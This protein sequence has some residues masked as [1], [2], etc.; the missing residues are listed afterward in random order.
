[1]KKILW[2]ICVLCFLILSCAS[3]RNDGTSSTLTLE[4]QE[5]T[6]T[7]SGTIQGIITVKRDNSGRII[8]TPTLMS[9]GFSIGNENCSLIPPGMDF[10]YVDNDT[11]SVIID[12]NTA[13][14]TMTDGSWVRKIF[15]GDITTITTS[16]GTVDWI[17][18]IV[19]GN[20]TTFTD[21]SGNL[22]TKVIAGNTITVTYS[23]G[24]WVREAIDGNTKTITNPDGSWVRTII[25]GNIKTTTFSRGGRWEEVLNSQGNTISIH[26]ER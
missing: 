8:I 5:Y 23:N 9:G 26:M 25:V 4:E 6:I 16:Y 14:Q 2:M 17:K 20:I 13:T 10:F 3:T 21:S 11:K 12:G 22:W 15:N 1:M 19:D 24:S 7:C 18:T